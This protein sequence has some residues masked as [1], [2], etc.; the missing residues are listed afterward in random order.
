MQGW[1]QQRCLGSTVSLESC[2]PSSV[3]QFTHLYNRREVRW[4]ETISR[5]L[6]GFRG[7]WNQ[8]MGAEQG[9]HCSPRTEEI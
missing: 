4:G 6:P 7:G 5:I 3:P 9:D 1:K 8:G 2:C